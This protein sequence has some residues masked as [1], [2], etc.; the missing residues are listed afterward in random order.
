MIESMIV[1]TLDPAGETHQLSNGLIE[2]AFKEACKQLLRKH[3]PDK[4]VLQP[5]EYTELTLRVRIG[6]ER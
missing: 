2:N 6:V 4:I 3:R 1:V 5:D